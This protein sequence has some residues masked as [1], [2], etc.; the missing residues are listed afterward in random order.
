MNDLQ[1][2]EN[3]SLGFRSAD[4][5]MYGDEGMAPGFYGSPG[6]AGNLNDPDTTLVGFGIKWPKNHHINDGWIQMPKKPGSRKMVDVY[7]AWG[8]QLFK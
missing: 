3:I 4:G 2:S 1:A 5:A 8:T 6:H 7:D